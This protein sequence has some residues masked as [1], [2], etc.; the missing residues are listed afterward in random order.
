MIKKLEW[1]LSLAYPYLA[2]R[3][4]SRLRPADVLPVLQA[5]G[6]R[7]RIGTARR[8][9]KVIG[10]V[11]RYAIATGRADT[12]PTIALRGALTE[13]KPKP[14]AAIIK[15]KEFDALLRAIDGFE[16]QTATATPFRH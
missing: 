3:D 4:I 11:C 2:D 15:P 13:H 5:V 8:L 10:S 6:T 1:M 9:R 12:D 14:R 7:G 16:G